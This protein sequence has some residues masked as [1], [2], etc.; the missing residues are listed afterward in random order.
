MITTTAR[1]V[2]TTAGEVGE[3]STYDVRPYRYGDL[4]MIAG[5]VCNAG[6]HAG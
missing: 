1:L 2:V 5:L 3:V 4:G 6:R